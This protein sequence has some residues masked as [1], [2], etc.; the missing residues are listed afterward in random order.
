MMQK[1]N[2]QR[3]RA[4]RPGSI[5]RKLHESREPLVLKLIIKAYRKMCEEELYPTKRHE[6]WFSA[7][8]KG[9]IEEIC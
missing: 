3:Q 7:I 6:V 4:K 8:L 5:T 1:P 2:I 9:C